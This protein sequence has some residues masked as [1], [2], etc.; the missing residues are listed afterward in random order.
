M[1]S[2]FFW[3]QS[4]D[5]KAPDLIFKDNEQLTDNS[6]R[7]QIV[8]K[9]YEVSGKKL[10]FS[11]P[12]SEVTIRFSDPKFVIET[13]PI[14][15][16]QANRL[17]PIVIYGELPEEFSPD[18]IERSCSEIRE[19]VAH[20]LNRTL[21]RDAVTKIQEWFKSVLE[22]KKKK[23]DIQTQGIVWMGAT[24]AIFLVGWILQ[25]QG[26]QLTLLVVTGLIALNNLLVM[27]LQIFLLNF[28]HRQGKKR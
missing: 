8:S 7:Q 5:N 25:A 3:A 21:N 20:K 10:E 13:L 9:I 26:I 12:N 28:F 23:V 16:D 22:A 14:E 24:V 6:E 17:A 2:L 15:K 1:K 18:W 27:T 19:V 11:S 4:L